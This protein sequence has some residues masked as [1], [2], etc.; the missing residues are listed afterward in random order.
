M[1][2]EELDKVLKYVTE[3][4][5]RLGYDKADYL[6]ALSNVKGHLLTDAMREEH[7]KK[8]ELNKS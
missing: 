3:E 2:T 1:T 6:I 8:T 7:Q 5:E 4:L